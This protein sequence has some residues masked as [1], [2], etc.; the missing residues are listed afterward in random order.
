MHLLLTCRIFRKSLKCESAMPVKSCMGDPNFI[1]VRDDGSY[2]VS[3][4]ATSDIY[5]YAT[6]TFSQGRGGQIWRVPVN[7][8]GA[9]L[10][11]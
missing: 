10:N 6:T 11:R 1:L 4:D 5:L 9:R 3:D 8:T 7:V 2:L